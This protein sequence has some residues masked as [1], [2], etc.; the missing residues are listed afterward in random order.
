MCVST[1]ASSARA[2]TIAVPAGGDLQA[3]IDRAQPGD[4]ITLAPQATYIGNFVLRYKGAVTDYIT[5]RSAAPDALLPGPGIR[6]TPA[7]AAQ[8]PVIKSPNSLSA[9]QTAAAANHWKLMFLEFQANVDG[10]GDIIALGAGDSSQTQLSQVPYALVLDRVYVHGDPVKGQKR[11]ISLNSRDTSVINSY[12]S[13][14]KA[15]GQDTQA[16]SGFNGPG[17]FV[18]E[19]NYLEA[20]AENFLLGGADP[21]IPNL[22]TTNVVFRRNYLR[23]PLAW[24]NPIIATPVNVSAA[25]APA[26]G[27]LAPDTYYYK[28]QARAAAGQLNLA[29]STASVEVSATIAKRTSGGVTISWTPVAGAQEYV[30][31]GR[32]AGAENMYWTTTDPYF[33]DSGAAGTSGTPAKVT[34]WAVKNIFELKNAQDVTIEGNIFE[35]L[36]VADQPGYP[37]VFTPRNQ[38][39]NAPWV[40]VQ[41]VTFQHNIVRHTAGGV[42]ILGTDNLHPSQRTNNIVIRNNIF[43]D[44]TSATWGTGSRPFQMGDGADVVTIDHNTIVTTDTTIYALYGTPTTS[45]QITNNMSVHSTY[46][47]FGSGKS[48]GNAS[49]AAYLPGSVVTANVLAGGRAKNYP[50]GN[51]F[52]TVA[53]WTAGFVDYAAGDYHLNGSSPYINAGADGEDVG[54]NVNV[55]LAQTASAQSGDNS[56]PSGTAHVQIVPASLPNGVVNQPYMQ[57][58]SC[59]GALGACAWNPVGGTLP[60]GMTFDPATATISGTPSAVESGVITVEAY[61]TLNTSNR[62]SAPLTL[63]IDAPP[64]VMTMPAAGAAQVGVPYQLSPSLSGT[65]GTATWTVSSG[66]LPGGL[67]LDAL[68]GAIG[69]VPTTWGTT[70]AVVT[71]QDSWGANRTD[72]KPFMVTVAPTAIAVTTTSLDHGLYQSSYY[73]VLRTSGGSGAVSWSVNGGTLPAGVSVDSN[74]TVSGTPSSTG[75]FTFGV[76][77]QDA[78]WPSN[79]ATQTLALTIDAPAFSIAV[80]APAIA[81]VGVPFQIAASS[82]G[83]VGSTI[84]SIA[85]GSLPGGVGIDAATGIISGVP[86]TFGSFVATVRGQDSWDTSRVSF[87]PAIINVAPLPISVA[88]TALAAGSVRQAYQ[89]TLQAT[90]GTGLTTWTIVSGSLPAGLALSNGIISG[91]PSAVGTSTFTVQ[92]ADAGWPGNAATKPLSITV[93]VREIV[94]YTSDATVITGTWSLVADAAAAGGKRIWNQNKTAAK[95][96]APLASPVNYFE[97]TFQAEAGVGY[98][99]WMRGKAD[100]NKWANDSVYVQYSGSVDANGV[101]SARIGSTSARTLSIEQGMNA[102]V[103]GWGWSDDEWDGLGAP[104]YFAAGGTQTIRVQVREDGLSIDQ[105]VLSAGAYMAVAP[106]AAKNDATIL[107]R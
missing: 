91:T 33:T 61:D 83:Q 97:I 54:A 77:A 58:L 70:T 98:H 45:S 20:A 2:A 69:G 101:A 106:G 21:T 14:C 51:F 6:M 40:A 99:L 26:A 86:A 74:G 47:L 55:V 30:V 29:T 22:I 73:A 56:G 103:Q 11:G 16:I 19:N 72:S 96:T 37:I 80:P 66:T 87:A 71:A 82:S 104:I 59:V 68:T 10:Y 7:F 5:I 31:Y 13:E 75:T 102:G 62:T 39:N 25:A 100:S 94:L 85:S 92:A 52:P 17:N 1:L 65:L 18:I 50:P 90:G 81:T 44:L 38:D 88:T 49:I 57:Q 64:F 8:L 32:A 36:W 46:G 78:N 43:D 105:I 3:A 12:I 9:V 27:S 42:N 89:A 63:T 23:K 53:A 15:V 76:T 48:A 84:W 95:R 24:R 41:R 67:S 107:P 28:V 79:Q 34:K 4:L 93:G 35:N 60:A